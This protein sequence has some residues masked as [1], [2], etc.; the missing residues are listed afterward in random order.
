[1]TL[2]PNPPVRSSVAPVIDYEPPARAAVPCR[3]VPPVSA[4]SSRPRRGHPPGLWPHRP[5]RG[6][7]A[8]PLQ[9]AAVF[10]DAA[11]RRVLE[12]IDGRRPT[13][14]LHPLL[15]TGLAESVLAARP[16]DRARGGPA[17]LQRV[18]VQQVDS[19]GS[20]S[21]DEGEAK[22]GPPHEP[23]EPT[24]AV[25]AFGTYRRGRRTHALACRIERVAGPGAVM[26]W[27]IVALHIG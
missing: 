14:H 9:S 12:A 24:S 22:L 20:A 16:V 18:R 4:P 23:A 13:A 1:M 2:N 21:L 5:A 8:G 10:A 7:L 3:P 11:L 27:Q 25:E 19:G 26:A 15:A 6:G 17:T